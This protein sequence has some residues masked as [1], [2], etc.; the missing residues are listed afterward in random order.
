MRSNPVGRTGDSLLLMERFM[1][2]ITSKQQI[3]DKVFLR[4]KNTDSETGKVNP[5]VSIVIWNHDGVHNLGALFSSFKTCR[6]YQNYE[7]IVTDNSPADDSVQ[8]PGQK[9]EDFPVTM[10]HGDKNDTFSKA[11][12]RGA[13]AAK[14]EYLLFLNK[15][16]RVTDY[17]LDGLLEIGKTHEDVGTIGARLVLYAEAP[18]STG[19]PGKIF[20]IQHEGIAFHRQCFEGRQYICPYNKGNGEE[21]VTDYDDNKTVP[22]AGVTGACILIKKRVFEDIGGFDEHYEYGYA[23][24]D[25]SLKALRKGYTNYYC[26]AAVLCYYE[27]GTLPNED[28][29]D[30]L[31]ESKNDL[32]YFSRRWHS[33]LKR[34]ILKDKIFGKRLLSEEPLKVAI[35]L[36]DKSVL[37][38][39]CSPVI[40][41]AAELTAERYEIRYLYREDHD[42]YD[43]DADIIINTV[44]E[45]DLGKIKRKDAGIISFAWISGNPELWCKS[46]SFPYYTFI[47]AES[48]ADCGKIFRCSYRNAVIFKKKIPQFVH[49]LTMYCSRIERKIAILMPVPNKKEAESWGDYHFAVAIKKCFESRGYDAEMRFFPEWNYPFDGKYVLVLRGLRKYVPKMEHFNIMWNISHPDDVEISE[50]NT[51]DINY[52]SSEIWAEYLKT[53]VKAPI[54]PLLQCSDTDVF[55]GEQDNRFEK[56]QILFVGNTRSVFRDVIRNVIPTKYQISVYGQG[57]EKFIEHKY[58]KGTVIPNKDLNYYYSN[59]DILLNDHWADMKEKG[60]VSNR[61]FD[62][63]A[64]GAFIITDKVKGL[65]RELRECVAVYENGEDL[66]EKTDYYMERP[67]LRKRM[68]S[69]GQ[70]LVRKKHTFRQRVDTMIKVMEEKRNPL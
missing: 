50:Y 62:G 60:F 67:E 49:L 45:Y 59:C 8:V 39:D 11:F 70:A 30:V 33:F 22:V 46:L 66:R 65:D 51:Y 2:K 37:H 68:A 69:L 3:E 6:F 5:L 13:E 18:D 17:W 21:A 25:L 14:G 35:V 15:N 20:K 55:T 56:T 9:N 31:S 1:M 23:D 4:N 10:I 41:F 40:K 27:S 36:Q 47:L 32:L 38:S 28:K 19:N 16:I 53:K 54:V 64:A 29:R 42:W 57:W 61:I 44:R 63:L 48:E 12:N 58:I 24:V 52:I 43:I 7:I 34:E 26:P